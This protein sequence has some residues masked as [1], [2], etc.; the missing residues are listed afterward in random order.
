MPE[1]TTL[2]DTLGVDAKASDDDIKRAYRRL[3]MTFH[4]D[5]RLDAD[6]KVAAS[7]H[8]LNIA[9][10][11]DVLADERKRM[12]YDELGD[13]HLEQG[14]TLV[15][16]EG[17][18]GPDELHRSFRRA[19]YRAF[20]SQHVARMGASGSATLACSIS[21]ALQPTDRSVPLLRRLVPEISS[22]A[23]AQDMSLR[24]GARDSV[25]V[26][27]QVLS[28]AGLGGYTLRLG[29]KRQLSSSSSVTLASRRVP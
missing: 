7:R 23:A 20:E 6:E 2:Y 22:F 10:A 11:Y 21:E 29:F 4:P 27:S 9:A 19:Q 25:S 17:V 13:R 8:W 12:V 3:S 16:S 24:L 14:L 15:R 26:S 18:S 1:D 5:R 28:K